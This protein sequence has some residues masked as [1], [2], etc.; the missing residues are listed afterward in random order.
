MRQLKQ[1]YLGGASALLVLG[2]FMFFIRA[3]QMVRPPEI[4]EL[5]GKTQ[6]KVSTEEMME[7]MQQMQEAARAHRP[8]PG[9]PEPPPRPVAAPTSEPNFKMSPPMFETEIK[10]VPPR[11]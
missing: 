4:P 10:Q 5:P 3:K 9:M 2:V 11:Q 7:Q 8:P 1:R 6:A